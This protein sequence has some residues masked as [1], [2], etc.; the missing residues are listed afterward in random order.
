MI[1]VRQIIVGG[2]KVGLADLDRILAQV[3]SE[4]LDSDG[5]IAERLLELVRQS[6]YV[7]PSKAEEY[8]MALLREFR[9]SSGEEVPSESGMFEIRVLG[10]GCP[11]CDRLMN[12]VRTMLAELGISAC[13]EQVHDLK[14]MAGF[15]PVATPALVI[16]GK[17]V[18]SGCV[19]QRRDLI[20]IVKEAW[21]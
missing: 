8:K 19:P 6:N 18:S 9:R 7:T 11:N 21:K 16:N 13:L 3:A 20:R 2:V 14:Q 10:Q 12:E 17:M 1:D 15:G 5:V 4:P